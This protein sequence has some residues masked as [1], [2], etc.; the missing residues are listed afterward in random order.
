[1]P[2]A[3]GPRWRRATAMVVTEL[4]LQAR[5]GALA[6]TLAVTVAWA[7]LLLATGA[8][9]RPALVPW[10]LFLDVAALGLFF[11]PALTVVERANGVPAA[12]ALARVAPTTVLGLRIAVMAAVASAAAVPLLLVAGIA[13]PGDVA[14]VL[15]AVA[16]LSTLASLLSMVVLGRA[17]TLTAWMTRLPIVAVPLLAPPLVRGIGLWDAPVLGL[18][19]F[20]GGLALLGGTWSWTTAGWLVAWI[21][22]LWLVMARVGHVVGPS[23]LPAAPRPRQRP[24]Q[25]LRR[26]SATVGGR[27]VA[28]APDDVPTGPRGRWRR[29]W[30]AA[31]SMAHVDRRSLVADGLLIAL[32]AGVPLTAIAVRWLGGP[33]ASWL[34]RVHGVDVVPAL[35]VVWAFVLVVHIPT[36]MGAVAGLLCSEDRDAGVLPAV[37]AT[38]SSLGTLLGYRLLVTA[39]VTTALVAAAVP[40][41]GAHHRLGA[42]GGAVTSLVAGAVA[43]VPALVIATHA[44]DRAGAMAITKAMSLPLYLPLAWWFVDGP[45]GWLFAIVPTAWAT[46]VAWAT[47]GGELVAFSLG[48]IAVCAVLDLAL[49]GRFRRGV[50]G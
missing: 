1:M 26:E 38:R 46:R 34:E 39:V 9:V 33:G 16:C 48:G 5:H 20:T 28:A 50:V 14:P 27:G 12:L 35:P 17:T 32:L 8:S 15:A 40:L 18:S 4:R 43:T 47:S 42:A 19:P 41:A 7:G 30:V 31:R 3:P 10:I 45:A 25:P 6:S 37:A 44:H 2:S 11:V 23:P 49:V 36:M 24:R 29:S 22:G 21:I 13:R